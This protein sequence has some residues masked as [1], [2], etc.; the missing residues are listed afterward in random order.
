[1]ASAAAGSARSACNNAMR[2]VQVLARSRPGGGQLI[3]VTADQDQLR[4]GLAECPRHFQPEPPA[5]A[6]HR[7]SATVELRA[8]VPNSHACRPP[9]KNRTATTALLTH[10]DLPLFTQHA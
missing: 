10:L 8:R 7:R 6:G 3:G 1:M 5:A 2:T 4:A 9:E